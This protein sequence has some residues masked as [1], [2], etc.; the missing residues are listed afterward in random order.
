MAE[1]PSAAVAGVAMAQPDGKGGEREARSPSTPVVADD[2]HLEC[3]EPP[4]TYLEMIRFFWWC[5]LMVAAQ[6]LRNIN[7][8]RSGFFDTPFSSD[9]FDRF[10]VS[11]VQIF[12]TAEYVSLT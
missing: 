3:R 12:S 11:H 4:V 6:W 7:T 5:V 9:I 8:C 1:K 2:G 10:V